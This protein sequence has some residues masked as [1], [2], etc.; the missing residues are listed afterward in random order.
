MN[1][2]LSGLCRWMVI[3]SVFLVMTGC[4][5]NN[6]PE[7]STAVI[8]TTVLEEDEYG[9][10]ILSVNSDDLLRA[11]FEFGD[12]LDIVF[13]NGKKYNDIPFY[14][15]YYN[16]PGEMLMLI[17][18]SNE[19]PLLAINYGQF[20]ESENI[21]D[22]MKLEISIHEKGK[23]IFTQ[24]MG[25]L[26]YSNNR[27]DYSSDEEFINAREVAVGNILPGMLYRSSSPFNPEIGR[28]EY[29][30][31]YAGK[32]KISTVLDLEDDVEKMA[33]YGEL[34]EYS[35]KLLDSNGVILNTMKIDYKSEDF[36]NKL[37]YGFS[38]LLKKDGPYLINCKEGKDRTGFTAMVLGG[39]CEATVEELE[40]DY[41]MSYQN[42]YGITKSDEDR[43]E[44]FINGNFIPMLEYILDTDDF[45]LSG[46]EISDRTREYLLRIGM[47]EDDIN[48]LKTKLTG[49]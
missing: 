28:N 21:E 38:E 32:H 39:L 6:N 8:N 30:S 13:E 35:Q 41:M 11:G 22:G 24:E 36:S 3:V 2:K 5:A 7:S 44:F 19:H 31:E 4:K 37:V 48:M 47:N 33:A 14:S 15:G 23:E 9:N 25:N 10:T 1:K 26:S 45:T 27:E 29:A 40:E 12:S 49:K 20:Y 46:K 18:G 34:P 42:Y 43:Y 17:Y 16:Q